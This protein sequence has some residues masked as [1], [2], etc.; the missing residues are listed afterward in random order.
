MNEIWKDIE[1]YPWKQVSN[2]WNV[3][4]GDRILCKDVGRFWYV[5][6]SLCLFG[7]VKHFSIHRLVA[8]AFIK[9]TENK[10][11]VNHKDWNKQNNRLENLEWCNASENHKHSYKY[12]GR[13]S[14]FQTHHPY[15][16]VFWK[17]NPWSKPIIQMTKDWE[18][19]REWASC[20]EAWRELN[21]SV[22]NMNACCH[23]LHSTIGWFKWK[24]II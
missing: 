17:D 14:N 1:W 4:S 7:I 9:N 20:T 5:R 2:L 8:Q 11:Q 10:P 22:T 21:I 16:W 12:L 19:I 24:F 13:V 3:K 15:K 23:W 6:V 18:F